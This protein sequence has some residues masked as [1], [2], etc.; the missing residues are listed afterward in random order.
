MSNGDQTNLVTNQQPIGQ[1]AQTTQPAQQPMNL[2]QLFGSM[3]ADQA[4]KLKSVVIKQKQQKEIIRNVGKDRATELVNKYKE[5]GLS[6]SAALDQS[7]KELSPNSRELDNLYFQKDITPEKFLALR[8]RKGQT[9]T[10]SERNLWFSH[11]NSLVNKENKANLQKGRIT[12]AAFDRSK[13]LGDA[14]V[15]YIALEDVMDTGIFQYYQKDPATGLPTQDFKEKKDAK[16]N[17]IKRTELDEKKYDAVMSARKYIYDAVATDLS[18]GLSDQ[19]EMQK[20]LHIIANNVDIEFLKNKKGIFI[21]N[22]FI[23][24]MGV[25]NDPTAL[26]QIYY[27]QLKKRL[28]LA[29]NHIAKLG[30][31]EQESESEL[32]KN[33][34]SQYEIPPN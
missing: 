8:E 21:D 25:D 30:F 31:I 19:K 1:P 3:T 14:K 18:G 9:Y 2:H 29:K 22:E 11:Y 4:L 20:Q 28:L 5:E 26:R 32:P 17:I 33:D 16:G 10:K 6:I 23:D 15:D 13:F 7:K 27:E 34:Y 24:L 12:Q